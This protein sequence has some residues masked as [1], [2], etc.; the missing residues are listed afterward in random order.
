MT[1]VV[2]LLALACLQAIADQED[3]PDKSKARE[4]N[5]LYARAL[6]TGKRGGKG[7]KGGKGKRGPPLD[8][9]MLKDK[10]SMVRAQQK[11][12]KAGGRKAAKAGGGGVRKGGVRKGGKGR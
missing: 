5:K 10:K 4:I 9:R 11:A 7:G 2:C 12:K 3:V 8:K 1:D 6:S